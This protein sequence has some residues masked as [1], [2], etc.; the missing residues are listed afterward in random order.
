MH[1][2]LASM[3]PR[4]MGELGLFI[5][6]TGAL[7]AA[8]GARLF[9]TRDQGQAARQGERTRYLWGALLLGGAFLLLLVSRVA[10]G[11]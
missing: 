4:R 3:L 5:G 10:G 2:T 8:S 6:M 11:P 7:V 9:L 1:I